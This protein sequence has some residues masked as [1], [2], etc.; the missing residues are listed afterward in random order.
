MIETAPRSTEI[1]ATWEEAVI[2]AQFLEVN[3]YKDWRLPT[4]HE[5]QYTRSNYITVGAALQHEAFHRDGWYWTSDHRD[6][7]FAGVVSMNTGVSCMSVKN[8]RY[9]VRLV[10]VKE[11][12]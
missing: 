11:V 12:V 3:G 4:I 9:Y 1:I 2:Y 5:L 6:L 8:T 7:N 10:R